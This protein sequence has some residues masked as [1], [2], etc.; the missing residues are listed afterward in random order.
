MLYLQKLI[1][2]I[3]LRRKVKSVLDMK[4]FSWTSTLWQFYAHNTAHVTRE[5]HGTSSFAFVDPYTWLWY[6][7]SMGKGWHEKTVL[8]TDMP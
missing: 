1:F 8:G 4:K 3:R 6:I 5:A 7:Y 2:D